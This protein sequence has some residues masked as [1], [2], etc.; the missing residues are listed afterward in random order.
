MSSPAER[1]ARRKAILS[2][3]S[4]RLAKLTTSARGEEATAY[5]QTG[6]HSTF[7]SG[8]FSSSHRCKCS[9]STRCIH[10]RRYAHSAFATNN[11]TSAISL[12]YAKWSTRPIYMDRGA[13]AAVY[14]SS[15]GC[16]EPL[17]FH[18]ASPSCRRPPGDGHGPACT[19]EPGSRA[20]SWQSPRIGRAP[21]TPYPFPKITTSTPHGMHVDVARLLCVLEGTASVCGKDGKRGFP[22][23][24]MA[25]TCTATTRARGL[26]GGT[27][28]GE[29]IPVDVDARSSFHC[30]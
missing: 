30:Q 12:L 23:G 21:P 17:A 4:D 1:A 8:P 3:G 19:G 24:K 18:P 22:P 28:C 11:S 5:I 26:V 27:T 7:V 20:S 14:A 16:D 10:R 15:H 6:G 13:T 29:Q 25:H 9:P 2:R